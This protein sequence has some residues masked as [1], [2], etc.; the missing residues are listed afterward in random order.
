MMD[1]DEIF[2]AFVSELRAELIQRSMGRPTTEKDAEEVITRCLEL[3]LRAKH[4]LKPP[5][6]L[7]KWKNRL[8]EFNRQTEQALGLLKK[9]FS[10]TSEVERIIQ[11]QRNELPEQ[12][13]LEMY[14]IAL[15]KTSNKRGPRINQDL[16]ELQNTLGKLLITAG[17]SQTN[18]NK[19]AFG[20]MKF[21]GLEPPRRPNS[22]SVLMSNK[23]AIES[24][25]PF[26]LGE[27]WKIK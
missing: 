25:K 9:Q 10:D 3:C 11:Q 17:L 2:P 6:N 27:V 18:A 14:E 4:P 13:L 16:S 26:P 7:A 23:H 15:P 8:G 5:P 19:Y 1:L 20:L 21:H 12:K 22:Q 24:E